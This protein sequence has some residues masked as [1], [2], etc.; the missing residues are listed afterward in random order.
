VHFV[1]LGT[2]LLDGLEDGLKSMPAKLSSRLT[3][4]IS[5]GNAILIKGNDLALAELRCVNYE[6]QPTLF[7]VRGTA[8]SM[9]YAW[10]SGDAYG[11]IEFSNTNSAFWIS[12]VNASTADLDKRITHLQVF[13]GGITN[14]SP[15]AT[16]SCVLTINGLIQRRFSIPKYTDRYIVTCLP[17]NNSP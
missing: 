14:D 11:S 16:G 7:P 10:P 5:S 13:L 12:Q 3:S 6:R 1:I 9:S 4:F 8:Y 15:I 2:N 17:L